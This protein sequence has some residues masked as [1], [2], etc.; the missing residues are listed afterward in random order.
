MMAYVVFAAVCVIWGSSFIL[1]K[2]AGPVFGPMTIAAWRTLGGAAALGAVWWVMTRRKAWRGGER[3]LADLGVAGDV[4]D[5]RSR[6]RRA[7]WW[8]TYRMLMVPVLIGMAYPWAMQPY[9]IHKHR[10][11]A[12]FGM[13]VGL[14][15][16][17]T[18]A[19]SVPL[20]KVYPKPRQV[21]GVLLGFGCMGLLVGVGRRIGVPW[22]DVLLAASVPACYALSNTYIKRSLSRVEPIRLTTLTLALAG[23]LLLPVG[24]TTEPI[25][26]QD[27]SAGWAAV[28]ALLLLGV[29]GTGLAMLMFFGLVQR[30]GPLF[31]GMVAYLVPVGALLWGGADNE[32]ITPGQ[33]V[34]LLGILAGVALVQWPVGREPA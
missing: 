9:L 14:V 29:V 13:M 30:R 25:T 33:V 22:Y 7:A 5:S 34:A 21:V 19:V 31:A 18:I 27:A 6:G 23:A 8:R 12:F 17:L 1:M 10:H 4:V 2:V 16:L 32:P 28:G 26:W 11:S 3:S 24:L 15:P 20:L